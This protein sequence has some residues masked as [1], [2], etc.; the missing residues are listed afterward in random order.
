[1][2]NK[3][4]HAHLIAEHINPSE[5]ATLKG[6]TGSRL[7]NHNFRPEGADRVKGRFTFVGLA[8]ESHL[9]ARDE[10]LLGVQYEG[11]ENPSGAERKHVIIPLLGQL[12]RHAPVSNGNDPFGTENPIDLLMKVAATKASHPEL[13]LDC[14][15]FWIDA[16][17]MALVIAEAQ[18]QLEKG[19]A[20]NQRPPEGIRCEIGM[21][22][23][24]GEPKLICQFVK[25]KGKTK[26]TKEMTAF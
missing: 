14:Y 7:Y 16:D 13:I 23:Y 9:P 11:K 6:I 3:P 21:Q 17:A 15:H 8:N 24:G 1:M 18:A 10:N 4:N 22:T 26:A 2:T 5:E 20:I 25:G 12:M 19:E